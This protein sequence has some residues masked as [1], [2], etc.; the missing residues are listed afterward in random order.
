MS[1]PPARFGQRSLRLQE[2][3]RAP[4]GRT[5]TASR[6]LE[7]SLEHYEAAY[8]LVLPALER[9]AKR[10]ARFPTMKTPI[11][12]EA[13]AHLGRTTEASDRLERFEEEARGADRAWALASVQH[14]RGVLAAA[15]DD[16]QEAEALLA[17]AAER[18]RELGL[19]FEHGRSLLALG[20]VRRRLQQKLAARETLEEARLVLDR[21]GARIWTARAE[22]ELRR[23]GDGATPRDPRSPRWRRKSPRSSAAARQTAKSPWRCRSAARPSSGTC[24][25]STARSASDREPSSARLNGDKP[26]DFPG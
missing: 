7:L 22:V 16:L 8:E 15:D 19:P 1:M 5:F 10:E 14:C 12:I 6:L 13:L 3:H 4:E 9:M 25:R 26:G 21:L 17:A 18:S 2:L 24:R 23:I 20:T 11:A